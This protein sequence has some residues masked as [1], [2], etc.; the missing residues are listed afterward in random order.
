LLVSTLEKSY[1]NFHIEC[2][3]LHIDKSETTFNNYEAAMRVSIAAITT[4]ENCWLVALEQRDYN[5]MYVRGMVGETEYERLDG[6]ANGLV[7]GHRKLPN[8]AA[9]VKAT[10]AKKIG[11]PQGFDLGNI[12][13]RAAG[14]YKMNIFVA[15]KD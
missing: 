15:V 13:C 7:K 9:P 8:S 14:F 12:W 2:R 3:Y 5:E 6:G 10:M 1:P 4:S 11:V